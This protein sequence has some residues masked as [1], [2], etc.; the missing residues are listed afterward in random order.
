M[1]IPAWVQLRLSKVDMGLIPMRKPFDQGSLFPGLDERDRVA[2]EA[3]FYPTREGWPVRGL[4]ETADP[5]FR[6]DLV[7]EHAAGEGHI[8]RHVLACE[9][10]ARRWALV[11]LRADA[12]ERALNVARDLGLT[13]DVS[14]GDFLKGAGGDLS[15]VTLAITNPAFSIAAAYLAESVRRMPTADIALLV[16]QGFFSSGERK[17]LL[18]DLPI[19][20]YDLAERPSFDGE[21]TDRYDYS[22][23]VTGPG[24]GGRW[25]QISREPAPPVRCVRCCLDV[26]GACGVLLSSGGRCALSRAHRSLEVPVERA[27]LHH[28]DVCAACAPGEL[29]ALCGVDLGEAVPPSARGLVDPAQA[30]PIRWTGRDFVELAPG[31]LV[32]A[33]GTVAVLAGQEVRND[34]AALRV[35]PSSDPA[36]RLAKGIGEALGGLLGLD[37]E[38]RTE[39]EYAA[40]DARAEAWAATLPDTVEEEDE[41]FVVPRLVD[42]RAPIAGEKGLGN[43]SEKATEEGANGEAQGQCARV[44]VVGGPGGRSSAEVGTQ[45]QAV[46]LVVPEEDGGDGGALA[47]AGSEGASNAEVSGDAGK[48]AGGFAREDGLSAGLPAGAGMGGA[49][50]ARAP[51]FGGGAVGA[52]DAR[53]DGSDASRG[54]VPRGSV[55]R[56]G[57]R[58]PARAARG[59]AADLATTGAV[60]SEPAL[61]GASPKAPV[62]ARRKVE[63]LVPGAPRCKV[64]GRTDAD[65][66]ASWC[67]ADV[68]CSRCSWCAEVIELV[69]DLVEAGVPWSEVPDRLEAMDRPGQGELSDGKRCV[70]AICLVRHE[71]EAAALLPCGEL[72]RDLACWGKWPDR[73]EQVDRRCRAEVATAEDGPDLGAPWDLVEA[74]VPHWC[75][76][77]NQGACG[78]PRRRLRKV[79][80]RFAACVNGG[81]HGAEDQGSH[82]EKSTVNERF[83]VVGAG[84]VREKREGSTSNGKKR[85]PRGGSCERRGTARRVTRAPAAT[86]SGPQT[87]ANGT[88]GTTE[89]QERNIMIRSGKQRQ[90]GTGSNSR[91]ETLSG[92]N[93]ED[94]GPS[95]AAC[96]PRGIVNEET[97]PDGGT[98]EQG[99]GGSVPPGAND[100]SHLPEEQRA[101]AARAFERGFLRRARE[102][103]GASWL[104]ACW[105]GA[106]GPLWMALVRLLVPAL[107]FDRVVGV[108]GQ[109]GWTTVARAAERAQDT[110]EAWPPGAARLAVHTVPGD[111]PGL[112]VFA[113]LVRAVNAFADAPSAWANPDAAFLLGQAAAAVAVVQAKAFE[114]R[115]FTEAEARGLVLLKLC[116]VECGVRALEPSDWDALAAAPGVIE[117][118]ER[119]TGRTI[120]AKGTPRD[121]LIL[122][123]QAVGMVLES[124]VCSVLGRV[125]ERVHAAGEALENGFPWEAAADAKGGA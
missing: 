119:L 121:R 35:V 99:G 104:P 98:G 106:L 93:P 50:Q 34:T 73:W 92:L 75:G 13:A 83:L 57:S 40:M 117:A 14:V 118:L 6:F 114:A 61:R 21:G 25:Y 81:R 74:C 36:L 20:R 111:S 62:R 78:L 52:D 120:A 47:S 109:L 67:W 123:L 64:C 124:N 87:A 60:Q 54:R 82:D 16:R 18:R 102:D 86:S 46:G 5:P 71:Q 3:E 97:H 4:I 39:E 70:T 51:V 91:D 79:V 110:A 63:R 72:G 69:R 115:G 12:A 42:L 1:R 27:Q 94:S 76:T 31:D 28:W 41:E 112:L 30:R 19:D 80:E 122:A 17:A 32:L 89:T 59:G 65:E 26:R 53:A 100:G 48:G 68:A 43:G 107:L 49:G 38:D 66:A 101:E 45:A 10:S 95:A 29:A 90:M 37:G 15:A 7:A 9:P 85:E 125:F 2:R 44:E 108:V 116:E 23:A 22:W 77:G 24:R 33:P 96:E 56:S 84:Q 103:Q 105:S 11:E 55:D 8:V 113:R 88:N 58:R